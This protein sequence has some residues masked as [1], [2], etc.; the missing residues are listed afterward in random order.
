V[1]V[2]RV[3]GWWVVRGARRSAAQGEGVDAAFE[4]DQVGLPGSAGGQVQ[5]VAAGGA[6]EP[7]G[8][9]EQRAL[10]GGEGPPRSWLIRRDCSRVRC[11]TSSCC[12]ADCS[13]VP[14]AGCSSERRWASPGR[15]GGRQGPTGQ[16]HVGRRAA[17]IPTSRQYPS[18]W[19]RR[20]RPKRISA[21]GGGARGWRP[22]P[23]RHRRAGP[24]TQGGPWV[25]RKTHRAPEAAAGF[26]V[27]SV[28]RPPRAWTTP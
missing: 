12:M 27:S 8:D 17:S 22:A 19:H 2:L 24:R 23:P 7:G 10:Q 20:A 21:A 11:A 26:E 9:R 15:A 14:S 18:R 1:G 25:D 3:L 16:V 5:V 13:S 4:P 28:I 6:G